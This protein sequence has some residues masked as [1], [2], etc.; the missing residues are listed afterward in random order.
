VGQL[1]ETLGLF[2]VRHP[3]LGVRLRYVRLDERRESFISG[4]L[5]VLATRTINGA[6]DP[7]LADCSAGTVA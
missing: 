7:L 4:S 1:G 5:K 6:H 2:F 3:H